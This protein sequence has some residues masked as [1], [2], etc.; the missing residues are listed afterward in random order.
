[1]KKTF[2]FFIIIF[3]ALAIQNIF[4]TSVE[5]IT[6][7]LDPSSYTLINGI[8]YI[9]GGAT[10][11]CY[12]YHEWPPFQT[13]TFTFSNG[14]S[15]YTTTG[16]NPAGQGGAFSVYMGPFAE[17]S[18]YYIYSNNG[19]T[20]TNG[21]SGP[22][23]VGTPIQL[24]T[25][26]AL[27]VV[28]TATTENIFISDSSQNCIF[29]YSSTGIFLGKL[30]KASLLSPSTLSSPG[31]LV[32]S[33]DGSFLY[34]TDTNNHRVVKIKL[35]LTTKE[36][37]F[38]DDYFD[39]EPRY[40][41]INNDLATWPLGFAPGGS[42]EEGGHIELNV[43][44]KKG[45]GSVN[46]AYTGTS[47]TGKIYIDPTVG[48]VTWEGAGV[49]DVSAAAANNSAEYGVASTTFTNG[50]AKI[51]VRDTMQASALKVT[52]VD[53]TNTEMKGEAEVS[54]TAENTPP[55]L[56]FIG[57]NSKGFRKF[58]CKNDPSVTFI[59]IPASCFER[60]NLSIGQIPITETRMSTY[61]IAETL[62]TNSQINNWRK[63]VGTGTPLL[64]GTWNWGIDASGTKG[65]DYPEHP[66][67]YLTWNDAKNYSY[68]IVTGLNNGQTAQYLPTAAQY[69][70]AARGALLFG[71]SNDSVNKAFPW[72]SAMDYNK[73]HN[74]VY[75]SPNER[76]LN[77]TKGTLPVT[78]FL[79][80]YFG[81]YDISGNTYQWLRDYIAMNPPETL[82]PMIPSGPYHQARGGS[83]QHG[84]LSQWLFCCSH[85]GGNGDDTAHWAS[86][87]RPC[88]YWPVQ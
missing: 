36:I 29:K 51:Y 18:N 21:F 9:N 74:A 61:F 26:S 66:A 79:Q 77:A 42:V 11:Q 22:F 12:G 39:I 20:F 50:T 41:D 71:L 88:F 25:P 6:V 43:T 65:R 81:L 87:F 83:W 34:V 80:G 56:E 33:D 5:A 27:T 75:S 59:K 15:T 58:I 13:T 67:I 4:I 24:Q 76:P 17:G 35:N 16:Y 52:I 37:E 45:D 54:W 23:T 60:G 1:M 8:G 10:I 14:V 70:K 57:A 55:A 62:T 78:C 69:E 44:A 85:P 7:A 28:S 73:C 48:L 84:P 46:T 31:G 30:D 38:G 68:W 82:D 3:L 2:Y 86:G 72:G 64:T 49:T 32:A 53:N 63:V 19:G 47:A 40:F